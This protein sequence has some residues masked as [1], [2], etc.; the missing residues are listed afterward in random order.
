M[1]RRRSQSELSVSLFPFLAVLVCAMGALI[2]LLLI[3]T[4][5]VRSQAMSPPSGEKVE[6]VV[7][8]ESLEPA[9]RIAQMEIPENHA[10][11]VLP[12]PE[13]PQQILPDAVLFDEQKD[14]DRA[15]M[16]LLE[17]QREEL[18]KNRL[19][20]FYVKNIKTHKKAHLLF[21]SEKK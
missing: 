1:S 8:P 13:I 3:I 21:P 7:T 14:G 6:L 18:E 10:P 2:L 11:A 12:E 5:Q 20:K 17:Q 16:R 9:I 19:W 4:K 15:R